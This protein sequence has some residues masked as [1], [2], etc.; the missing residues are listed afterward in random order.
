LKSVREKFNP[1]SIAGKGDEISKILNLMHWVHNNIRHDGSN[2]A[3]CEFNAIDLYNYHKA[4][5]KGI[6]CRHLAIMLNEIYLSASIKSRFITCLPK[7]DKDQDCHVINIVYSE[8]FKKWIWIDPTFN[9]Y[10]KDEKGIFLSIEE[11]RERLINNRP[12]VLNED[13]NWNNEEKQTKENY[14]ENYMAK[15]LYWLQCPL[16]SKFNAES[17]Y[18][19]NIGKYIS[20]VPEDFKPASSNIYN[21]V[22]CNSDYFW[23]HSQQWHYARFLAV[24]QIFITSV[25]DFFIAHQIIW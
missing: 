17:R 20:L 13:A 21:V 8:T 15:N 2:Y 24:I 7:N 4:T 16:N 22:T 23:E 3:L 25:A 18:R 11:V 9:A 19:R 6:N 14:L 10:V 5:N 1:D 12:L